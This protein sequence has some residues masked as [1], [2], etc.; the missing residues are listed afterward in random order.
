MID[1]GVPYKKIEP[2]AKDVKIVLATHCHQ[3]HLKPST[4]KRLAFERPK[5]L[6]FCGDFLRDKVLECGVSPKNIYTVPENG[7]ASVEVGGDKITLSPFFLHHD[8]P[9]YGWKI[10]LNGHTALYATDTASLSHVQAYGYDLYM[11]EGNYRERE[12]EERVRAK[13]DAGEFIYEGRVTETH[14]SVE[15]AMDW[16]A[17]NATNKSRYILLHGH[18]DRTEVKK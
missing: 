13:Q 4:V 5:L 8:V 2:F 9:N 3:D 6:W 11:V 12:L 17:N 18:E 15:Q 7:Q 10:E 1:C 16:L 14:L